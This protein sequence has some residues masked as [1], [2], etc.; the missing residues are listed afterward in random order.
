MSHYF[1]FRVHSRFVFIR[2]SLQFAFRRIETKHMDRSLIACREGRDED[3]RILR[4]RRDR[5]MKRHHTQCHW[6]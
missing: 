2:I 1:A 6:N 4:E 3:Q 5:C